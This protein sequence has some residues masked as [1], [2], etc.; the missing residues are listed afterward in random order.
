MIQTKNTF[1]RSKTRNWILNVDG[2][3]QIK[4]NTIEWC[5]TFLIL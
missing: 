4:N 1:F 3:I 2:S 5:K